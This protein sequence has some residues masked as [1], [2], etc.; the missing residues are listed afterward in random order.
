MHTLSHLYGKFRNYIADNQSDQ[1]RMV[2]LIAGPPVEVGVTMY[3]L[4]ISSVSEVLMVQ[5]AFSNSYRTH[6]DS[7]PFISLLYLL[8]LLIN[9]FPP[10]LLLLVPP[11]ACTVARVPPTPQPRPVFFRPSPSFRDRRR[12]ID[13]SI[14]AIERAHVTPPG[15]RNQLVERAAHP[16]MPLVP[17][18]VCL[19]PYYRIRAR[20]K[21]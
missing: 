4:S 7:R 11:R 16:T 9:P 2:L 17:L 10:P 5:F 12:W 1:G 6:N 8:Y 14:V 20:N 3:V 15:E 21:I 13:R 19:A 18:I